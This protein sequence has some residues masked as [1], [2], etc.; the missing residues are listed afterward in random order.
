LSTFPIGEFRILFSSDF[1]S[2]THLIS[3]GAM[4]KLSEFLETH[5]QDRSAETNLDEIAAA[6]VQPTIL[7]HQKDDIRLLAACCLADVIRI[8]APDAPYD[9]NTLEV[10][11]Q[12]LPRNRLLVVWYFAMDCFKA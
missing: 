5:D 12:L 9:S 8:Y 3:F 11:A 7:K 2:N 10:R 4:Q 6:L 1:A